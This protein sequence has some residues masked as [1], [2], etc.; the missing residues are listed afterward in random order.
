MG[1]YRGGEERRRKRE[2]ER[3]TRRSEPDKPESEIYALLCTY[4]LQMYCAFKFVGATV[5]AVHKFLIWTSF[6][7]N[8]DRVD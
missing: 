6:I 7:R 8:R 4:V 2:P 5:I 1:G 3:G